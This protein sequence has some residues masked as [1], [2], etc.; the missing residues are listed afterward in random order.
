VA[1]QLVASR[2]VLSFTEL[3]SSLIR[4]SRISL[5]NCIKFCRSN[6]YGGFF[7]DLEFGDFT[8]KVPDDFT[9]SMKRETGFDMYSIILFDDR[10][11]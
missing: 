5:K 1:A 7:S 10:F 3:F 4:S 6:L 2:A 11:Q 9:F 8:S